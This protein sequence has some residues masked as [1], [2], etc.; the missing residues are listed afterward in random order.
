MKYRSWHAYWQLPASIKTRSVCFKAADYK[1]A[2]GVDGGDI[3]QDRDNEDGD[4]D[5]HHQK[6]V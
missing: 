1:A 6:C 5:R 2:D 4:D 3:V